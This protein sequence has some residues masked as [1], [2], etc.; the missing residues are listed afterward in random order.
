MPG[1]RL[2]HDRLRYQTETLQCTPVYRLPRGRPVK[3]CRWSS[4][5]R[6]PGSQRLQSPAFL[7]GQLAPLA[8]RQV[9]KLDRADG[10][11][12]PGARSGNRRPR[13]FAGPGGCVPREESAGA[14]RWA[15]ACGSGLAPAGRGVR[16]P[17]PA[18]RSRQDASV[19]Q[20]GQPHDAALPERPD[21]EPAPPARGKFWG[22]RISGRSGDGPGDRRR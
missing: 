22:A 11:C 17:I 10:N 16:E 15:R 9:A 14:R 19:H 3:P 2:H 7:G 12:A 6:V 4:T 20:R 13:S 8:G 18:A 21:R 5:S 1:I